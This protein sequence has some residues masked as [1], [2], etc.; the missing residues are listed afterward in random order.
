MIA[1]GHGA[2]ESNTHLRPRL[3]GFK[4]HFQINFSGP[5]SV[6]SGMDGRL[7]TAQ[8]EEIHSAQASPGRIG[9]ALHFITTNQ[10]YTCP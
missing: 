3:E 6:R 1:N 9:L 2:S 4:L 5:V 10:L 8:W 7:D